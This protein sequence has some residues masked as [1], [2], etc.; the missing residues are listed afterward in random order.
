VGGAHP[1]FYRLRSFAALRMIN[2]RAR[3]YLKTYPKGENSPGYPLTLTLSPQE[4]REAE[5]PNIPH[6]FDSPTE[7]QSIEEGRSIHLFF[8]SP[9]C[10]GR[11]LR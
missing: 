9:P 2:K 5:P 6:S 10:E 4:E 11:G 1:T 8:S 3:T 7:K